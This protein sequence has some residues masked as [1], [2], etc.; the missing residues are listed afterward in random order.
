MTEPLVGSL[1][2]GEW[3]V[4]AIGAAPADDASPPALA[5]TREGHVAG[6]TGINRFSGGYTLTG[7]VLTIS[8]LL[9][10]RMAGPEHLMDQER[11]FTEALAAT[12][13]VMLEDD[14]LTLGGAVPLT[15]RAVAPGRA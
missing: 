1:A 9:M 10:T 11:R 8:P 2:G 15:L 13:T 14:T 5:F 4:T 6:T 7:G 3:I 12:T